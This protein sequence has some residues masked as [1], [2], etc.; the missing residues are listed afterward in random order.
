VNE[1][2]RTI[3]ETEFNPSRLHHQETVFSLGNGYLGTRGSFEEGYPG[4]WPATLI[5]G[6]YDDVPIVYT[7]LANCPDWTS[8]AIFVDGERFR[9]DRGEV[10]GYERRLD[11]HRGL[12][13]RQ[14]RW[15]SPAGQTV[16]FHFERFASL[17][18]PHVLAVQCRITPLDFDGRI[19]VHAG[20]NGY[21]DN[22]GV[23]HWRLVEQGND[24]AKIWLWTR[25]RHTG[26]ELGM[27][28]A[29]SVQGGKKTYLRA[30]KC[31]GVPTQVAQCQA[32][33]GKTITV[34][35]LVTVVDSRDLERMRIERQAVY[36]AQPPFQTGARPDAFEV[37]LETNG[38]WGELRPQTVAEAAQAKLA[39][40][41]SQHSSYRSLL[42]AH[43]AAWAEVWRACDVIIEGDPVAQQ[44]IRYN[45]F[46]VLAATPRSDDAAGGGRVSIGAKA[47]SGFGYRGHVFWDTEIFIVPFL[48]FTQPAMASNLLSY[49]GHTLPGARRKAREAGYE[50][51]MFAWESADSG[52]EVTP[53]WV[54]GP[55]G[56]EWVRIWP[57]DIEL[58]I[59]ADVAYATWSYWRATGDDDWMRRYGAEIL[60]DTA[61][62]WGS[63]AEWNERRGRYEI[64]DV[65]GP[66]EY[67]EHVDNNA[68]TN[69][70]VRWHLETALEVLAWLRRYDPSRAA[71]LE[72]RLDLNP[73]RLARWA[74]IIGCMFVPHDPESGLIEQFE[75]F[76]EREDIDLAMYEPRTQSMQAILG[77]EGANQAQVIKQADVLMLL[78]LL[79]HR[80]DRQTLLT[81]W[82]FY[83]SHTDHTYGSSLGPCVHAILACELGKPEE[84]YEHFMR[85]ALV[86]LEDVRGNAADGIHAAS[87]GG[88]WQAAVFG[89][90][91]V[92][93]TANG[94]VATPHLPAPWTRLQFRLQ[95]RGQWYTFDLKQEVGNQGIRYQVPGTRYQAPDASIPDIQGIIFDLDG[96]LTDTS[97]FHYLG[98]KRLADEEG[99]P[100][101]RQA[102]EALRGIERRESLLRILGDRPVSEEQIE[103][104]MARKNHYY[105]EVIEGVTASNLLP[106]ARQLL[107]ELRAAGVKVAIGSAS[108]NA[109]V[110]IGKL[111]IGKLVDAVSDG[112]SVEQ[113]KPAPDL[114]LH[115]ASQLGLKLEQ[116][117][118]VEDAES[119]V[120]AALAAGMW[121]VG[122]GPAERV[123]TAHIVLPSLEGVRWTDIR[124]HLTEVVKQKNS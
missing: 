5:H 69:E 91:G 73:K 18:D 3:I 85:A 34:T 57:G 10:L 55:M 37:R 111:G 120:E 77:I 25:T 71:E 42:S 79:R 51:A 114:F 61:V 41:L 31:E 106:G 113:Q 24:A 64:T 8:L 35:K 99:L 116:C 67:H 11:L 48:T 82:D 1:S 28:A 29:L 32:Q 20:I 84:A 38:S 100:F 33:G 109:R 107:E 117:A 54:P 23:L 17:A 58:H 43:E 44:A 122:L 80:Y 50:G 102:N 72:Q 65:I 16:D 92:R 26:S 19:E 49:R 83:N 62:F 123:G 36:H 86:D 124:A 74:D 76:F 60:L 39:H 103:A 40:L 6:L 115:A 13:A 81:N 93:L 27:A 78:Y 46:Q 95:H 14:V 75:G 118:V 90:G 63:R 108:K 9:L 66:D 52:D 89:F 88:L 112:Y 56:E 7:E 22:Q 45:L 47:L 96:V 2:D 87:A 104:M 110:V 15:R 119:G 105:Q 101:D 12:L 70:M 97:E 21:T 30:I 4:A 68:F 53:R 98:W 94:P 59:S 121:A